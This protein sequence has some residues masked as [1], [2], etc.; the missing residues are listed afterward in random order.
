[1]HKFAGPFP[2]TKAFTVEDALGGWA[3][4][5]ADHFADGAIYDRIVVKR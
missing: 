4:V 3:K 2:A 1:L 5:Q